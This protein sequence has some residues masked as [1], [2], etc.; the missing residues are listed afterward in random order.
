MFKCICFVILFLCPSPKADYTSLYD[1]MQTFHSV[2]Q[3][4]LP[5]ILFCLMAF[6]FSWRFLLVLKLDGLSK[7]IQSKK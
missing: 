7:I 2:Y 1:Y 4:F 3:K 5:H 6:D